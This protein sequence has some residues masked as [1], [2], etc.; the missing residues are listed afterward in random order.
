M[1]GPVGRRVGGPV[2][3]VGEDA[4]MSQWRMDP[5]DPPETRIG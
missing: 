3:R 1:D 5:S 2:G 4:V